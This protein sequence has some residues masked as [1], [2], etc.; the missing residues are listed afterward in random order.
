MLLQSPSTLVELTGETTL[1]AC[2]RLA[3]EAASDADGR[4]LAL[5][6]A[7]AKN[8]GGGFLGG[9]LAQEESLAVS[10][11]L[12]ATLLEDGPQQHYYRPHRDR[13]RPNT[14]VYS[15]AM[16]YSPNVPVFRDDCTLRLLPEPVCCCF[17]TAPAVNAG[18]AL[19]RGVDEAT[20]RQLMAE[21]IRRVLALA[22]IKGHHTLVLG[23]WGCGVFRNSPPMIAELFRDELNAIPSGAARRLR[24]VVFAIPNPDGPTARAFADILGVPP[25]DP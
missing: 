13:T 5:N 9:S 17:L 24:R 6:F 11:A 14:G 10:S 19:A 3:A 2:L 20:V 7:S 12:Y 1:Q 18:V 21:R 25:T 22:L 23:A 4:P 15:H 8:P 16:V